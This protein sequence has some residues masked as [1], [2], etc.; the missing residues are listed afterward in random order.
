[1]R[2]LFEDH[3]K[4]Q[5]T[6]SP[7][8]IVSALLL[9]ALNSVGLFSEKLKNNELLDRKSYF[10]ILLLIF[11]VLMPWIS[12]ATIN[13]Q[14]YTELKRYSEPLDPIKA[15]ELAE[16]LNKYT[17]GIKE[18]AEDVALNL[19]VEKDSY[20]LAQQL[21]LNAN[22]KI[23]TPSRQDATYTVLGGE[24]ITQIAEKFSLHV[25]SILDANNLKAE[26]ADKIKPQT[27]LKIPSSDTSTSTDWLVAIKE[28]EEKERE[29]YQKK[30]TEERNRK[31]ALSARSYASSYQTSYQGG[32]QGS[33]T[34]GL[35]TPISSRSISQYFGG[36]HT[37][38]DYMANVGTPVMAASGG[39][40]VIISSGWSGGY[41]NQIVIDHGSGRATRYAHL[42]S[43]NVG[44][45]GYVSRGQVI[46]YS[47]NT[48]RSSGPHLHFELIVNGRPVPPF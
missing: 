13:K 32:Y 14:I 28:A 9:K 21:S 41:G 38:I 8:K 23:D 29:E 18:N 20:T 17:P 3:Q 35:I 44:T 4:K 25:A 6:R 10:N 22:K 11:I 15:G 43:I 2:D 27:V 33:D 45:G 5:E 31:L 24:T 47:G 30:L 12:E 1:M 48:G 46:A 16:R 26:D 7:L 19:L 42:S 37:G 34:G 39:R 40:V 36:G